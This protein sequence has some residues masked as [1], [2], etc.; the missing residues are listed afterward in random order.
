MS[1]GDTQV[2]L[3]L[4]YS[5][6][7][8]GSTSLLPPSLSSVN[9]TLPFPVNFQLSM[10]AKL[11]VPGAGNEAAAAAAPPTPAERPIPAFH[12]LDV[13]SKDLLVQS[14]VQVRLKGNI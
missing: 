1:E 8:S 10:A 5:L 6:R 3:L 11:Q 7:P 13:Y 12:Y 14:L 2:P 4:V 9:L